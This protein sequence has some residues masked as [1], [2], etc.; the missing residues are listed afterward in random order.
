[1]GAAAR[2]AEPRLRIL[3]EPT[4][5]LDPR[6]IREIRDLMTE[7]NAA[8]TTVFLSSHLLAEGEQPC[9][10]VGGLDRGRRGL[11]DGLAARRGPPGRGGLPTSG[12]ER[13]HGVREGRVESREGD[14][15]VVRHDDPAE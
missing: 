8:G 5:G 11:R 4:K 15:L 3:G 9:P 7:L 10:R 14:R 1:G 6:G 2:L 12:P 13:A